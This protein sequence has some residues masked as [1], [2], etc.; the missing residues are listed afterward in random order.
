MN[1]K[2]LYKGLD[3]TEVLDVETG[4]LTKKY[5]LNPIV[6]SYTLEK[7]AIK[8]LD[9]FYSSKAKKY[10]LLYIGNNS[11]A[12]IS[13]DVFKDENIREDLKWGFFYPI[14]LEEEYLKYISNYYA[15]S[16]KYRTFN[17]TYPN[18]PE[19]NNNFLLTGN[20]KYTFGV[21]LETASGYI[22]EYLE[23]DLNIS[24]EYDGSLRPEGGGDPISGEYITGILSGNNGLLHLQKICMELSKR[25]TVDKKTSIHIH[26]GN[27]DFNKTFIVF[28]YKLGLA[29]Q[30]DL[31]QY[32]PPS[33]SRSTYCQMLPN[34]YEKKYLGKTTNK[35][36]YNIWLSDIYNEIFKKACKYNPDDKLNKKTNHPKGAKVGYDHSNIRYAW[37]N[38]IPCLFN[39]RENESY[40]LEFRCHSGTT[41]FV[42]VKNWLLFCIAFVSFVENYQKEIENEY[43]ESEKG[44]QKITIPLI[45]ECCFGDNE[46]THKLIEYF[47]KRKELF[48][49]LEAQK[50]E[51]KEYG[52]QKLSSI[53][54]LTVKEILCV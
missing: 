36:E 25:C 20:K 14:P 6:H 2:A 3:D 22:P 8:I 46:R 5:K 4:V 34:L 10:P 50:E 1:E 29:I 52:K 17:N 42:K 54:Q 30:K 21:E 18:L 51:A 7:N 35:I 19:K 24:C 53:K 39:T 38:F 28:A 47:E 31:F 49:S 44:I 45:L 37:L 33:R 12:Y 9:E 11:F 27:I 23:N 13:R 32:L 40:T 48:T 26:L 43:F 41:N 16:A 15:G